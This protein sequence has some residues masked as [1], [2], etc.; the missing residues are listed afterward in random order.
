MSGSITE[1]GQEDGRP[2]PLETTRSGRVVL[3]SVNKTFP[4]LHILLRIDVGERR[5]VQGASL[6][7]R[8]RAGTGKAGSFTKGC[9]SVSVNCPVRCKERREQRP[10]AW[11]GGE[12]GRGERKEGL[13]ANGGG[14]LGVGCETVLRSMGPVGNTAGPERGRGRRESEK[15]AE[16][17]PW[18]KVSASRGAGRSGERVDE[19]GQHRLGRV[20]HSEQ[21]AKPRIFSLF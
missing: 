10:S 9:S 16:K 20:T 12:G 5:E 19:P 18:Q 3:T 15:A 14:Q 21:H 7:V 1:F 17:E 4:Y 11:P 6:R 8:Q 2:G 13:H